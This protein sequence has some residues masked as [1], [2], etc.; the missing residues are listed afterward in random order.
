MQ[1]EVIFSFIRCKV[2]GENTGL[3]VSIN[4]TLVAQL[5]LLTAAV[6]SA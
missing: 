5:G 3:L 2:V 1:C 6:S 4:R